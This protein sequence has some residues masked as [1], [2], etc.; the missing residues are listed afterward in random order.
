MLLLSSFIALSAC[1]ESVDTQIYN[2][3]EEAVNLEKGFEDQQSIIND[4]E[5]QEQEIYDQ[6]IELGMDDFKTI[7]ELAVE[8]IAVIEE[9]TEYIEVE[10]NSIDES[11]QEFEKA[12]SLISEI[13]DEDTKEKAEEMYTAMM[14]RYQSYDELYEAYTKSLSLERELYDMLQQEEME[15]ETITEHI[16]TINES[17]D[18]VIKANE[19][20]NEHT[21]AYNELKK[22]YYEVADIK[23]TYADEN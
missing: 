11:R 16:A 3:L 17:Y 22:T 12:E 19:A 4:L 23:V 15:Q 10:K 13:D 20:F 6:I 21:I 2:H 14:E 18:E 8:A 5:K 7:Q 1:G 9:R